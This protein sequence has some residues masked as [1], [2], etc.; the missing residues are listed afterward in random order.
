MHHEINF[1][2]CP[3]PWEVRKDGD[4]LCIFDCSGHH[5]LD[6]DDV[7]DLVTTIN[8]L[9]SRTSNLWLAIQKVL[10]YTEKVHHSKIEPSLEGTCPQDFDTGT[11][12]FDRWNCAL[13]EVREA[14]T[15]ACDHRSAHWRIDPKEK[16]LGASIEVCN[17]C[18]LSRKHWEQGESPWIGVDVSQYEVAVH[19][20]QRALDALIVAALSK[21]VGNG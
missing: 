18:G 20:E 1:K 7:N 17:D 5:V 12:D 16:Q 2:D 3:L 10:C 6:A 21:E 13:S 15:W 8:R 9:H 14:F 4:K 11:G 19:R